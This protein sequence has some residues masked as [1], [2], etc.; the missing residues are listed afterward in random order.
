MSQ[1]NPSVQS[2]IPEQ[3]SAWLIWKTKGRAAKGSTICPHFPLFGSQGNR[4]AT[5]QENWFG[6][7]LLR[8]RNLAVSGAGGGRRTGFGKRLL[9]G[10]HETDRK[11]PSL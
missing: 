7:Q 6:K 3:S 11:H 8:R 1:P 5:S 10:N 9:D 2:S 4:A